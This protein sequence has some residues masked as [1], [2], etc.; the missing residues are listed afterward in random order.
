MAKSS[1]PSTAAQPSAAQ[2]KRASRAEAQ[3]ADELSFREAQTAL[4]LCLAQLQDQDLDVETMADLYRRA[5]TYA[6]RCEI[7]LRRVEQEVMQWD[8]SHHESEPTPYAP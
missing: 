3:Q 2:R 5:Q 4:E 8:P 6:D 7:V 1:D